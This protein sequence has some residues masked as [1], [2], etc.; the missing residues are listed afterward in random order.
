MEF[1][2]DPYVHEYESKMHELR[3]KLDPKLAEIAE[4][5]ITP[6]K[7]SSISWKSHLPSESSTEATNDEAEYKKIEKEY[8]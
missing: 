4:L 8:Y 7:I 6:K 3:D 5:L 1:K 2:S